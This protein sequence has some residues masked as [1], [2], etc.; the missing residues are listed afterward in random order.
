MV[1][2]L[3]IPVVIYLLLQGF[4]SEATTPTQPPN[5]ESVQKTKYSRITSVKINQNLLPHA[6]SAFV[7]N[8]EYDKN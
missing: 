4:Y 2:K 6:I 3:T 1:T 5:T 8:Q 7:F